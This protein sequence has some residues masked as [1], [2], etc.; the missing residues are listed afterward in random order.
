MSFTV[1]TASAR[2]LHSAL[3]VARSPAR[4]GGGELEY[5]AELA[6]G[7]TVTW[8]PATPRHCVDFSVEPAAEGLPMPRASD[9][10][11]RAPWL[12]LAAVTMLDAR[13]QLPL[14]RSVLDAEIAA[15]QVAAADT[16][17]PAEPVRD[18]LVGRALVRA[19]RASR[20]LVQYLDRITA[21]GHR[22]PPALAASLDTL[23]ACY[24]RLCAEVD[25]HDAALVSVID[26]ADRLPVTGSA[27]LRDGAGLPAFAPPPCG[28]SQIDPRLVPARVLRLGPTVDAAEIDVAPVRLPGEPDAVRIQAP[29]FDASPEPA[30]LAVRLVDRRDGRVHGYGLLELPVRLGKRCFEGLVSLPSAIAADDVRVELYDAAAPPPPVAGG[31]V[32]LRR[33][34]RATLFLADW[35][36]LV[37]DTRLRGPRA[38]PAARLRNVILALAPDVDQ[39]RDEPLWAGGPRLAHLRRIAE[40]GDRRLAAVLRSGARRATSVDAATAAVVDTVGGPGDLLAAE[41]AA[42]YDRAVPA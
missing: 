2:F 38:L 11:D 26:A 30:D 21:A 37:A 40:L 19:R 35:R 5:D 39:G 18:H 22:P 33:A 27:V 29:V 10:V 16:L 4:D 7:V 41:L 25:E 14:N 8:D 17:S 32:E 1:S 13:L 6:P 3:A 15:A 28:A 23:A 12:R 34:R 9:V 24:L 42:A 31:E 36:T 20:G